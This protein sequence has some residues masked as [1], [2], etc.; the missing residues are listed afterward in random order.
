MARYVITASVTMWLPR[1]PSCL[2]LEPSREMEG[3][4]DAA[5]LMMAD[6]ALSRRPV[7]LWLCWWLSSAAMVEPE[8]AEEAETLRS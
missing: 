3:L 1:G 4:G 8:A 5:R 2:R 7:W 6:L